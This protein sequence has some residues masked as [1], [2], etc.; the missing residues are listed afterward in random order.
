MGMGSVFWTRASAPDSLH[1]AC[2]SHETS[3]ADR[4]PFSGILAEPEYRTVAAIRQ[5]AA[6]KRSIEADGYVH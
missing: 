5:T 1:D 6:T 2:P 4:V 3:S